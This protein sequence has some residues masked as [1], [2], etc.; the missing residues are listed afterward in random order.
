MKF[1]KW[2][3]R[4]YQEEDF[5]RSISTTTSGLIGLIVYLNSNDWV[6]SGFVL[7]IVFPLFRIL[8]SFLHHFFK[9]QFG[10]INEIK[11]IQKE[12]EKFS[13]EEK[14]VLK[15]FAN[16]GGATLSLSLIKRQ[17]IILHD[18]G[19]NSLF[20]RN[21]LSHSVTADGISEAL[22]IDLDVFNLALKM[23]PK[24]KLITNYL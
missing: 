18:A 14:E 2:A 21:I 9:N 12:F 13:I 8:A 15:A 11:R 3:T 22:S 1:E 17:G 19:V 6:L 23:Y 20:Q 16:A 7:I 10:T 24:E 4:I 5:G